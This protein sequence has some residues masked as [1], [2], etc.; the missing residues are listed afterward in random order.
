MQIPIQGYIKIKGKWAGGHD[1]ES[2]LVITGKRLDLV[3][4]H[5]SMGKRDFSHPCVDHEV[6]EESVITDIWVEPLEVEEGD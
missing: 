2:L 5:I 4:D 1:H 3:F 6:E